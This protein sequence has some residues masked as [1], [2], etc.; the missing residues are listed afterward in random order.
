MGADKNSSPK[1][2]LGLYPKFTTKDSHTSLPRSRSH[3]GRTNPRNK[4]QTIPKRKNESRSKGL[5]CSAAVLA[6]G[7]RPW[8]G[9]FAALGRTVRDHRADGPRHMADGP[10]I[11]NRMTQPA[12]THTDG[13]Y[14]VLGRSA[15]NSCR[16]VRNVP[17]DCPPN[18]FPH[19]SHWPTRSKRRCSR[20][21][22][23]HEE[24]LRQKHH[25]DYPHPPRGLSARCEN[26]SPRAN[27]RAPY[28]LSFHGSP[29]QLKLLW[30]DLGK[31]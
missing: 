26:S 31:M 6:D 24:H 9:R 14:H 27:S 8:G 2:A 25:A 5:S 21:R 28:Q 3:D 20:T 29:K 13:L 18:H 16:A 12:P 22:E 23:E 1:R 11:T 4:P 17:A 10:L 7:P 19:K 30:K 15:S